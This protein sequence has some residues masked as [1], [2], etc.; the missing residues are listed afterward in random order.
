MKNLVKMMMVLAA[1]LVLGVGQVLAYPI[2]VNEDG[3]ATGIGL[4]QSATGAVNGDFQVFQ[5]GI[6][7]SGFATF[8]LENDVT[9][10][11][12]TSYTAKISDQV[13]RTEAN[14]GNKNL[15][16]GTKYLYWNFAQGTL[17]GWELNKEH[18]DA[19]QAAIW[20]LQHFFSGYGNAVDLNTLAV[21]YYSSAVA[22]ASAGEGLNVQVM[23]LFRGETYAQSQLIIG[24]AP[25]PEP[26]TLLLLGSGL[27]GLA[28]Y[29]RRSSK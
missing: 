25:V 22:N 17:D 13:L 8:C 5:D 15:Y 28:L 26:G 7:V 9:F 19:L 10:S 21:S 20:Q 27:A 2:T 11:S 29:R 4:Q 16:G 23:N 18:V 24:P 3:M 6:L 14:G 1:L 12:N